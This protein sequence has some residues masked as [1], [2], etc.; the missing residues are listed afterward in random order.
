MRS[1][2]VDAITEPPNFLQT[3][4]CKNVSTQKDIRDVIRVIT[5]TYHVVISKV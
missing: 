3:I 5:I 2:F 1:F 4:G